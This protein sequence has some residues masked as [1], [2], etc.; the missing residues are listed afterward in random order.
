VPSHVVVKRSRGCREVSPLR[1]NG[2]WSAIGENPISGERP[3]TIGHL[4]GVFGIGPGPPAIY[5][6]LA[7]RLR[8]PK[9][10]SPA[11][12][13]SSKHKVAGSGTGV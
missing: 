10:P 6:N 4:A 8:A 2:A 12:P 9:S 3:V 7:C 13:E 1:K 11:T 5:A